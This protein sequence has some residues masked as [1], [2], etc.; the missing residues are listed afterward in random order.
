MF[1][2][3]QAVWCSVSCFAWIR[4]GRSSVRGSWIVFR[5]VSRLPDRVPGSAPD[6]VRVFR[7]AWIRSCQDPVTWILFACLDRGSGP[8]K[9]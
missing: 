2:G 1:C 3:L 7:A 4:S 8:V 5:I 6:R 9:K